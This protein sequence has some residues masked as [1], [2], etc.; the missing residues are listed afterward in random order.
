[1]NR[2]YSEQVRLL[3]HILPILYKERDFAI[4]GGTAINLFI[5]DMPRYSIDID[6]T[7]IPLE[8]REISLQNINDKLSIIS[9]NIKRS[10][11]FVKIKIVPD[12]LLCMLG[13]S[14]VKIEVNGIKRGLIGETMDM[15]LCQRAQQEF[16]MFCKA[17]LVSLTQLYGGKIGA[18]LSRQHPRDLFDYKYMAINSFESIRHGLIFNILS[19]QKPILEL[20][21]PN[22]ISQL[23]ALENQFRGMTDLPFTYN[24]YEKTRQN[25]ILF[26]NSN[27]TKDDKEFL[28]SF[29]SANPKWENS[30]YH[31][32]H[33]PSIKWKLMNLNKLK[34]NNPT[35]YKQGVDK[36]R[37]YLKII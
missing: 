21:S 12:K 26:V 19:S 7:Y 9:E 24:D 16:E 37:E 5:K 1:M 6:L 34:E 25:L 36:L 35:K 22:P 33:Y 10:I 13:A 3:L 8:E 28:I 31:F 18:A 2:I 11:P 17:R 15:P 27:L 4:H 20:L 14:T 29:E 23:Q 32:A 30:A